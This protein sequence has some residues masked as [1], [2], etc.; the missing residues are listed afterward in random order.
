MSLILDSTSTLKQTIISQSSISKTS[1]QLRDVVDMLIVQLY[2]GDA[3]IVFIRNY[4]YYNVSS[5]LI[6]HSSALSRP[7]FPHRPL[8]LSNLFAH[9]EHHPSEN[10][11][12]SLS[13]SM[14]FSRWGFFLFSLLLHDWSYNMERLVELI[15]RHPIVERRLDSVLGLEPIDLASPL[16]F[17]GA[18]STYRTAQECDFTRNRNVCRCSR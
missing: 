4:R 7:L 11:L 17:Q 13:L 10:L 9:H 8:Y 14:L 15:S 18:S 5:R 6:E 16:Q 1:V 12:L 3:D 2:R